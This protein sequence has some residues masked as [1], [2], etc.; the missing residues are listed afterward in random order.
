[1][2][3]WL[4]ARGS[5]SVAACYA[6]RQPAASQSEAIICSPGATPVAQNH[7]TTRETKETNVNFQMSSRRGLLKEA[8]QTRAFIF[9]FINVFSSQFLSMQVRNIKKSECNL[10]L[11]IKEHPVALI[12]CF[13]L[14]PL[15]YI[16]LV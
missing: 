9:I 14:L 13:R 15:L 11:S 10:E 2:G 3:A 4:Q 1:M 12:S 5:Y 8:V 16:L 6:N 7:T